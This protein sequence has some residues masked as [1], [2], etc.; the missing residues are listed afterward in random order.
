M[1]L[2]QP[3]GE[4]QI[5][6]RRLLAVAGY[7]F[8]RAR[9]ASSVLASSPAP[10][11]SQENQGLAPARQQD[12][13][14]VTVAG[15]RFA[16]LAH[17]GRMPRF[18][19]YHTRA[20]SIIVAFSICRP[21]ADIDAIARQRPRWS[22][23]ADRQQSVAVINPWFTVRFEADQVRPVNASWSLTMHTCRRACRSPARSTVTCS[24]RRCC[25]SLWRMPAVS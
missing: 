9:I 10:I 23:R 4:T 14:R 12:G 5:I 22:A 3:T 13:L 19:V 17:T 11:Q 1:A 21:C 7:R 16:T 6:G 25:R 24:I 20:A 15:F 18:E 2:G 8:A